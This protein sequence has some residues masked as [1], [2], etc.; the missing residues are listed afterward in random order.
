[1]SDEDKFQAIC[2]EAGVVFIRVQRWGPGS[3]EFVT[4]RP[5]TPVFNLRS[6]L[7]SVKEIHNMLR[8][9]Q[10]SEHK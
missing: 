10:E 4:F 8:L 1:M 3:S 7:F 5:R 6:D 2:D 9:Y